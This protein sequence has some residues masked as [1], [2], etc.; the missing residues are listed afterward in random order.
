MTA[1]DEW[2]YTFEDL[3]KLN[4]S[5]K[6]IVYTVAEENVEG[7]IGTVNGD[8]ASGFT[9][10]NKFDDGG[11]DGETIEIPVTK[12]WDDK[13]DAAKKR[14][15]EIAVKLLANG[16]ETGQMIILSKDKGWKGSFTDLPKVNEEDGKDIEYTVEEVAIREYQASYEGTAATGFTIKNTYVPDEPAPKEPDKPSGGS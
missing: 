16:E 3:P 1:D 14:P 9:I 5:G 4:E 15:T 6:D 13:N 8:A 7:Y 2:S 12:E 10:E 11:F